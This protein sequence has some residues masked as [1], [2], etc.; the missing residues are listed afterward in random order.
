MRKDGERHWGEVNLRS[1]LSFCFPR[2]SAVK[3][4][5][6]AL[7]NFDRRGFMRRRPGAREGVY[8]SYCIDDFAIFKYLRD[9][10]AL[11][12][13][14]L[15]DDEDGVKFSYSLS[16]NP[17][18]IPDTV[19]DAFDWV[20]EEEEC[21]CSGRLRKVLWAESRVTLPSDGVWFFNVRA[22]DSKGNWG[23]AGRCL[24]AV[25]SGAPSVSV[26]ISF[27]RDGSRAVRLL[28]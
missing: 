8:F 10:K 27:R 15:P 3:I 25:D 16:K 7:M 18:A 26:E 6:I 13:W 11:I 22:C 4:S 20:E 19:P 12:R 23:R 2:G 24:L 9:R 17:E 14:S 5:E 21:E 28:C 1:A